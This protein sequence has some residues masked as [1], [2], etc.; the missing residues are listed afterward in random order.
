MEAE[1]DISDDVEMPGDPVRMVGDNLNYRLPEDH[2][3]KSMLDKIADENPAI[4]Y[5]TGAV[6]APKDPDYVAPPHRFHCGC[7]GK[8]YK[9]NRHLGWVSPGEY[10]ADGMYLC[11]AC[12]KKVG[13]TWK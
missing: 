2:P 10:D 11:K 6:W 13:E 4:R 3:L 7:C 9:T 12:W 5:T 1:K 8:E